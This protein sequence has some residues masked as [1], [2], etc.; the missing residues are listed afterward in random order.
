MCPALFLASAFLQR[1]EVSADAV[2]LIAEEMEEVEAEQVA[3]ALRHQEVPEQRVKVA[4][5]AK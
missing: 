2:P 3:A 1:V 4:M 5:V